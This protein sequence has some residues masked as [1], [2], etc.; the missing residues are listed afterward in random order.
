MWSCALSRKLSELMYRSSQISCLEEASSGEACCAGPQAVLSILHGDSAGCDD[1]HSDS[2][3]AGLDP[4]VWWHIEESGLPQRCQSDRR[5]ARS[6]ENRREDDEI[7][8]MRLC[9]TNLC[10]RMA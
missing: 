4:S 9:R 8:A 3:I 10:R 1:R 7:G 2:V 5:N 6:L